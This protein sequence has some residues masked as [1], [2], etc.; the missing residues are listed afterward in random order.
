MN[1]RV[2]RHSS[3]I[4]AV[5]VEGN[6]QH[7]RKHVN[8]KLNHVYRDKSIGGSNVED[9]VREAEA[10]DVLKDRAKDHDL[11]RDWLVAI[12]SVRNADCRYRGHSQTREAEA[13]DNDGLPWPRARVSDG[14][15][16]VG[17][18]EEADKRDQCWETHLG[19][20]NAVVLP[21]RAARQPVREWTSR[22][23]ADDTAYKEGKVGVSDL[24]WVEAV[25][26]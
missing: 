23:D 1:I 2:L 5:V 20:T 4:L 16:D 13:T 12:D 10:K 8:G 9:P 22:G 3:Q 14:A 19:L 26:W 15:N 18:D 17:D 21:R 6:S 11:S 25:R 7:H 24:A